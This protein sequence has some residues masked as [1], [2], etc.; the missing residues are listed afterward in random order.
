MLKSLL[1]I[2]MSSVLVNNYVLSKYMGFD[3][4]LSSSKKAKTV[5]A[6][7]LLVTVVMVLTA[8][9]TWP[10]QTYVIEPLN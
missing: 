7:G 10:L 9:V 2:M 5:G 4:M 1:S 6:M 8:L 3:R